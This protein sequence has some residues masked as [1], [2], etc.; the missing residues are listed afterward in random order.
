MKNS[1]TYFIITIIALLLY[2]AVLII[3]VRVA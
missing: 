1:V 2:K 3:L